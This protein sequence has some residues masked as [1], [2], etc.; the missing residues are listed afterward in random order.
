M[1]FWTLTKSNYSPVYAH[2][3]S[4][5]IYSLHFSLQAHGSISHNDM[6]D[7]VRLC[8]NMVVKTWTLL[9]TRAS[10]LICFS[11]SLLYHEWAVWRDILHRESILVAWNNLCIGSLLFLALI[12]KMFVI[13]YV[14]IHFANDW[15]SFMCIFFL[16][17][18]S[19]VTW[20]G[21][22]SISKLVIQSLLI[23]SR[24]QPEIVH[25][26]KNINQWR[27]MNTSFYHILGMHKQAAMWP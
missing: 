1:G 27:M 17:S 14:I 22:Y 11:T 21:C 25:L 2:V 13:K 12:I 15:F 23:H 5:Y 16:F 26:M 24:M 4:M 20:N 19:W 8:I 9:F 18:H 7:P 6:L 3:E 10:Q